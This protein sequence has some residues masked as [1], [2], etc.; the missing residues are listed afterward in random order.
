[1]PRRMNV[2]DAVGDEGVASTGRS[3]EKVDSICAHKRLWMGQS[4]A[5]GCA[6]LVGD[7]HHKFTKL[8][9]LGERE[10]PGTVCIT[11][12]LKED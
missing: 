11:I 1:M 8:G 7:T 6:I 9:Q 4:T 12:Q 5:F 10:D 2:Q 3:R